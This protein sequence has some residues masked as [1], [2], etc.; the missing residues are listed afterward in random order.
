MISVITDKSAWRLPPRG[1]SDALLPFLNVAFA[2]AG[3]KFALWV[4]RVLDALVQARPEVPRHQLARDL[5][6]MAINPFSE[7]PRLSDEALQ[8]L[9]EALRAFPYFR[10]FNPPQDLVVSALNHML[11]AFGPEEEKERAF[12]LKRSMARL[13]QADQALVYATFVR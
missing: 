2:E 5:L 12:L 13:S 1:L 10:Y 11:H 8:S 3:D 7:R 4:W 9:I 6:M